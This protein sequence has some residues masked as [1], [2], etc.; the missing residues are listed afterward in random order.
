MATHAVAR[1][2]DA[3]AVELG[4]GREECL[5][6]FLSDVRV[7]LVAFA[8]RLLRSIHVEARA[9]AKVVVIIFALDF[10]P[11]CD[12]SCSERIPIAQSHDAQRTR[13][14]VGVHNGNAL[15]AGSVLKEAFLGAIV[16]RASQPREVK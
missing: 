3:V 7:H 1:D 11:S 8:V 12:W 5:W 14:C 6:E 13:T 15:L 16:T 10:Q 4:E 9:G 2:A